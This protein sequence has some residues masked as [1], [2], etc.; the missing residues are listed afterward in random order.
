MRFAQQQQPD[1]AAPHAAGWIAATQGRQR[2]AQSTALRS[3]SPA[4]ES[5]QIVSQPLQLQRRSLSPADGWRSSRAT[6][7]SQKLAG[8]AAARRSAHYDC[9]WGGRS[10]Y[11]HTGG[12]ALSQSAAVGQA[13]AA[14]DQAGRPQ[15]DFKSLAINQISGAMIGV[16]GPRLPQRAY[17]QRVA[18]KQ[19]ARHPNPST[20]QL[21]RADY[22][23]QPSRWPISCSSMPLARRNREQ[24]DR[25]KANIGRSFTLSVVGDPTT[26]EGGLN[27]IAERRWTLTRSCMVGACR[28][29]VTTAAGSDTNP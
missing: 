6:S 28:E 10:L 25:E 13:V 16:T 12:G 11:L 1:V 20:P 5:E 17:H 26:G 24:A 29:A 8:S 22:H 23:R 2:G 21:P 14:S 18:T 19:C 27:A 4:S 7:V 9:S 15:H 3:A